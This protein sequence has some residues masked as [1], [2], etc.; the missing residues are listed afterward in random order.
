MKIQ[1]TKPIELEFLA[2]PGREYLAAKTP[3]TRGQWSAI[4]GKTSP[5]DGED[6]YPVTRVSWDD[7]QALLSKWNALP[8]EQGG[9]PV[10]HN[11]AM[12]TEEQWQHF[13][14]AGTQKDPTPLEDYAVFGQTS[15]V[16]VGTKKPNAWGLYDCLGLVWEWCADPYSNEHGK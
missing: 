6:N 12:P 10:G 15:L 11:Y 8:E 1:I 2:I 7:C 5:G 9:P 3:M 13:A 16:P 14:Q 4:S